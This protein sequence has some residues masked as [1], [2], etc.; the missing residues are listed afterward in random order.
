MRSAHPPAARHPRGVRRWAHE[1]E[2]WL[3]Q[4]FQRDRA[5]VRAGIQPGGA[6]TPGAR[7]AL[8]RWFG[9][10]RKAPEGWPYEAG[11]WVGMRIAAAYLDRSPDK[12]AAIEALIQAR[13]PAAILSA[14]GYAPTAP[15]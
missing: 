1:R 6:L 2:A 3:W 13:D 11:Y 4:E 14:S 8:H 15:R 5:T 12:A 10:Y 9:N 7:Q